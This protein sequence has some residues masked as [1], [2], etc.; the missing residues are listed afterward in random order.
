M[1]RRIATSDSPTAAAH[2]ADHDGIGSPS[3]TTP[4]VRAMPP[5]RGILPSGVGGVRCRG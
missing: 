3:N 2:F 1:H 5:K 4:S